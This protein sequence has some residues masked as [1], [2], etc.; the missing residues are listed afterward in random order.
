MDKAISR[1]RSM[2]DLCKVENKHFLAREMTDLS[3]VF[4]PRLMPKGDGL[5]DR[6]EESNRVTSKFGPSGS[7]RRRHASPG[8]SSRRRPLTW[9]GWEKDQS[10]EVRDWVRG[11]SLLPWVFPGVG[12]LLALLRHRPS[13]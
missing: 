6:P 3:K 4:R 1:P 8:W 5:D 12:W 9:R 13:F 7:E 2:R 10:C 11:M